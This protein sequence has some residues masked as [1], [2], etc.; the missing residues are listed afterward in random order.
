MTFLHYKNSI[1]NNLKKIIKE[2]EYEY[3]NP[4]ILETSRL[5]F[6][7]AY[8]NIAFLL[9]KKYKEKPIDIANK[10]NNSF[11]DSKI[12]IQIKEPGYINFFVNEN[13]YN[14][15]TLK[16]SIN[17]N[18]SYPEIGNNQNIIL[19]HTS[20]NPNK[21]LHIG[22]ARNLIIGDTMYRILKKTN[23]NLTIVNYIDNVGLQIADLIVGF[24]YLNFKT[25][26]KNNIK[27]DEY[28]GNEVY[29]KVNEMY[30]KEP[31][32]LEK[33]KIILKELEED[34][35][36]AKFGEKI[37]NR[38]LHE[39]LKT[40]H[41][42][43]AKY[44]LIIYESHILRSEM[45]TKIF[46]D[47][48]KENIIS[49]E[50]E[51]KLKGTWT[52][53]GISKNIEEK[54]LLRSDGTATYIA[55][56]IPFAAW[57]LGI[58]NNDFKYKKFLEY[59]NGNNLLESSYDKDSKIVKNMKNDIAITII[60]SRQ[61]EL[62]N[63]IKKILEK[64]HK[65]DLEKKYVHLGYEIVRLSSQTVSELG[66]KNH[67]NKTT[68]MSGRKGIFVNVDECLDLIKQKTKE[69]T[70]KRNPAENESWIEEVAES[71]AISAFRYEIIK[72]DLDKIVTFDL[73]DALNLD[74]DTGPYI[75]YANARSIRIL[76]KAGEIP[77]I[78]EEFNNVLETDE[79]KELVVEI[80]KMNLRIKE[81]V[82]NSS[83][84][85]LAKYAYNLASVFNSFY[86][87]NRVLDIEDQ[88]LKM[89]RLGLVLAFSATIQRIGELLGL[90]M[91]NKI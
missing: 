30:E 58:V 14:F 59:E 81:A 76:E 13:D 47:M 79:E 44:D 20:V 63:I 34:S 78:K 22:H 86:E 62:Q 21:A 1:E 12:K 35:E 80:S 28:A 70:K 7:N 27:F 38:I 74:G 69:E 9:A 83:P 37:T 4:Q 73:K 61:S 15:R 72:Q 60:D 8:T 32:L 36:I 66:I 89:A 19:E 53:K 51:G 11:K 65:K 90:K 85:I 56:D 45:W 24:K 75:L 84:K 10:I 64:L 49:Y 39:Q 50:K 91:P 46:E 40:A 16:E 6:G 87:K 31:N 18:F 77:N 5:E 71:L 57:K 42:L 55:K 3:E 17:E 29:V 68:S 54:V 43:G 48:K 25:E 82:N 26:P 41:R 52:I 2:L 67:N 33:R 88:E 23:Y